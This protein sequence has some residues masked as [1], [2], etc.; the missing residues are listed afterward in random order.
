MA[1]A[2]NI[3]RTRWPPLTLMAS[4]FGRI[5]SASYLP[6]PAFPGVICTKENQ[7]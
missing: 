7:Q 4:S 1:P 2:R 6:G 5:R 3:T